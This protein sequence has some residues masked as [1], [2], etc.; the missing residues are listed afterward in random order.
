MRQPDDTVTAD[1]PGVPPAKVRTPRPKK[2]ATAA[3][4]QA[5]YRARKGVTAITI[6]LTAD[7]ADQFRTWLAAKGKQP[8]AVIE[9]L[10]KTQLLRPR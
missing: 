6:M 5:A 10:I 7:V 9:K 4:K 3:E 1:L 2:Y 8:S